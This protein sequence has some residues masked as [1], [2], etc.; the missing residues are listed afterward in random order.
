MGEENHSPLRWMIFLLTYHGFPLKWNPFRGEMAHHGF[1]LKWNPFPL[2]QNGFHFKGKPI[3]TLKGKSS[4]S[5]DYILSTQAYIN[6]TQKSSL[7]T[8]FEHPK[9]A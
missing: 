3:V 6:T 9:L 7:L 1:P 4:T 2:T 8:P 5:K